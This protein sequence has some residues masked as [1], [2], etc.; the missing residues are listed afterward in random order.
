[1]PTTLLIDGLCYLLAM[2]G[3]VGVCAMLMNRLQGSGI[4]YRYEKVIKKIVKLG[5]LC[6]VLVP[7]A[8]YRFDPC[9]T[10]PIQ[11]VGK[12][13]VQFQGYYV[14][15]VGFLLI[16]ALRR[17]S[18]VYLDRCPQRWSMV[19]SR[20]LDA[21]GETGSD[22]IG[23]GGVIVWPRVPCNE[24][25]KLEVNSKLIQ[26][27]RLPPQLDG[28]TITHFSD[29]HFT[30]ILTKQYF[31]WVLQKA[32]DLKSDMIVVTGDIIDNPQLLPWVIDLFAPLAAQT[33]CFYVL[34]NH[35]IRNLDPSRVREALATAGCHDLGGQTTTFEHPHCQ[36][37]L[38]GNEQPWI[39]AAPMIPD[40]D[41]DLHI[42]VAHTPDLFSWAQDHDMHLLLAGHAHGG[43]I[44]IPLVGPVVTP[45]LH[46]VRY[47]SGV[48]YQNATMM[49]VTRGIGGLQPIRYRCFP[50]ITQLELC[51][52]IE[53]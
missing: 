32:L 37:Q 16:V 49:H 33:R 6:G 27:D 44:R 23:S 35:D 24:I 22:L 50:E 40:V 21:V 38:S 17:L 45:S 5:A 41:V 1:M 3:H 26:I 25:R 13:V 39:G 2:A 14:C 15:T 7:F 47:A 29:L 46:G 34:G 52:Q 20:R 19:R 43:Q 42:G 53:T 9:L 10:A 11:W 8:A 36:I 28:F 4:E 48:F 18:H 30:G 12:Q 51:R 31:Q